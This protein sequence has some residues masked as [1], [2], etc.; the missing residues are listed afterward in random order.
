[1]R[2]F[3]TLIAATSVGLS[4][5][6]AYGQ[7]P[8]PKASDVLVKYGEVENWTVYTNQTRGDCLIVRDYGASS[9]QMGVTADQQVGYL[10]VFSKADIGLQN[11]T[12]SEVFVSIGGH[13]YGGVATSTHGELKG[14]Y[15]GGYILTDSPEFKRDL[16]KKYEMIVFPET[17]GTFVV[18]LKGTYKAMAMGRKCLKH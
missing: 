18:D 13:L 8:V 5:M 7:N 10:G 14:G 16:A 1:M 2:S 15:S 3:L 4:A 11:G 9:V 6:V 12:K 17:K